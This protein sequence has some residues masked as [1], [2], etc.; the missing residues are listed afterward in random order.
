MYSIYIHIPF[1]VKRCSY[2]D[3][4]TYAGKEDLIPQ[5]VRAVSREIE[6]VAQKQGG[7]LPVHTVYFGGG[8]PSILKPD[9]L[10][11]ILDTVKARFDVVPD[12]EITFE[13]NPETIFEKNL[14]EIR[15]SG[16]N[17]ISLGVQSMDD[18]ELEFLGRIQSRQDVINSFDMARRS[19]FDNISFDLL[20]GM[21]NQKM[22]NWKAS[23]STLV[24]LQPEH[25][26]LYS[27]TIEKG[28]RF[29]ILAKQG[30]LNLPD[31]DLAAEM[32]MW[33]DRFL[34]DHGFLRYEISNWGKPGRESRHNL[35]Y[36]LNQPYFGFGAGAHGHIGELRVANIMRIKEYIHRIEGPGSDDDGK[37][38]PA[39]VSSTRL[40]SFVQMQEALML[41]LRLTDKGVSRQHFKQEHAKD[42]VDVFSVEIEKLIGLGLLEWHDDVLRLTK[43]GRM[44][45]NRVFQEFV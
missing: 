40:N 9:Q 24:R 3:F 25:L 36:W 30:R 2:C 16:F 29:G 27:L 44:M 28:T 34:A 39:T 19:G 35:Q 18:E 42:L 45:G 38:S 7:G 31:D 13:A 37:F 14:L 41:G 15:K 17:R 23:L 20:Y 11:L 32:L 10:K 43:R 21:P 26:S 12:A 1:C 8:T 33:A 4:N 6:I 5:Y 22:V